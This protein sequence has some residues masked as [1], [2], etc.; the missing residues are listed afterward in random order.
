MATALNNITVET[1]GTQEEAAE[2]LEA[3]LE[4]EVEKTGK[5]EEEGEGN[6]RALEALE[7]LTQDTEPR[8]TTL[9]D[10]RNGFN[11]L[12]RLAMLWNVRHRWPAGERFAFN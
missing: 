11:D 6:Q 10:A 1:A 12:S 3:V 4:M 7:F 9:I 5:G 2:Q 8:G